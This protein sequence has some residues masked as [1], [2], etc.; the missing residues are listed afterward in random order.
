[1]NDRQR[2]ICRTCVHAKDKSTKF[3]GSCYCV[4]FGIIIGY[5]KTDCRGYEREQVQEHQNH[6]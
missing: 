4:L 3:G 6:G 1:L 5:S 2:E